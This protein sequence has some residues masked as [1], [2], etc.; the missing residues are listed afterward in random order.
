METIREVTDLYS[1]FN[2]NRR[3]GEVVSVEIHASVEDA[4]RA[5]LSENCEL[6]S[7]ITDS[8]LFT[9]V[10]E[11]DESVPWRLKVVHVFGYAPTI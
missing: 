8:Y 11:F 6:Y 2:A 4:V 5:Q 7:P 9:G 1:I 10:N 3:S